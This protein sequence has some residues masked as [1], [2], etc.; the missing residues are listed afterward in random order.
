MERNINTTLTSGEKAHDPFNVTYEVI[1]FSPSWG[2]TC[3]L[4][5]KWKKRRHHHSWTWF[6]RKRF[7]FSLLASFRLHSAAL[8]GIPS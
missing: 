1:Y 3:A 7:S 6:A 5:G 8:A 2:C 4:K